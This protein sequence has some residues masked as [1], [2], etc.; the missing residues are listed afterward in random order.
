MKKWLGP[1]TFIL[2]AAVVGVMCG[3]WPIPGQDVAAQV[4]TKLFMNALRLVSLP[5]IFLSVASTICGMETIA[6]LRTL[7]RRVASYT[8]ATTV[9]AAAVALTLYLWLD[10]AGALTQAP[11]AP[12]AGGNLNYFEHLINIIP[13]NPFQ[14]FIEGNVMGVLLLAVVF[15]CAL[16]LV[17]ERAATQAVMSTCLAALMRIIR[18]I[19]RGISAG[20]LGWGRAI[21]S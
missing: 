21:I 9:A 8:L 12:H 2:A 10:P 11:V 1:Q 13:T 4:L 19:C 7:G 5:I 15:A 6:E 14:P 20:G 3:V 18:V 17:P 16:L